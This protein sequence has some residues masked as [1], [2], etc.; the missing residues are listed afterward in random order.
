MSV[1][2]VQ[3]RISTAVP[4]EPIAPPRHYLNNEYGILSWLL[5]V[6]HKR[7]GIL[8]LLSLTVFFT[9]GGLAAGLVRINL[10]SPNGAI[11]TEDQYNRMFTAHGVIMLFLFLIPSIPAVMGNFLIPMMI[12][13][14]DLAFPKLNLASWYV[15]MIGAGFMV[16]SVLVGGVDT[17]WTLYPPYSSRSHSNVTP[18]VFGVFIN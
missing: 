4:P 5:T 16:W 3:P 11:L 1:A 6:D 7:I 18:G 15:Y 9:V 17:G 8:Y 14:K 10:L 13:A 12:G 2:T